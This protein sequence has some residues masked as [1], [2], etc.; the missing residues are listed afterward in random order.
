LSDASVKG[1]LELQA[2]KSYYVY[3]FWNNRFI[4]K[5]SGK[6]RLAQEIRPGEA[7][8]MSVRAVENH[9]QVLSTDRHLM[10]GYVELSDVEWDASTKT[11]K[12]KA[13]LVEKEAMTIVIATNGFKFQNVS[14]ENAASSVTPDGDLIRLVLQGDRSEQTGWSVSFSK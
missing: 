1:G 3:D 2:G 8:V 6:E 7:R 12:G 9:P 5:L 11:L 13:S 14:A 10:Q 4:G